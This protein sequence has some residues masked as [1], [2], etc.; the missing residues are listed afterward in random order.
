M[1]YSRTSY[2]KQN[3]KYWFKGRKS[4]G[5][6]TNLNDRYF[7]GLIKKATEDF[8]SVHGDRMKQEQPEVYYSMINKP[9]PKKYQKEEVIKPVEVQSSTPA[10]AHENELT[11]YLKQRDIERKAEYEK[12]RSQQKKQIKISFRAECKDPNRG[13]R[14]VNPNIPINQG[15]L[16]F[17]QIVRKKGKRYYY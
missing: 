4:A 10:I 15:K 1:D 11:E 17:S 13:M 16:G 2:L 12:I 7:T 14:W 8:L 3:K 5:V 6:K 9:H